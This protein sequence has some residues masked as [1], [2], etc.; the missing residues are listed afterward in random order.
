MVLFL[1]G[2]VTVNNF[3]FNMM[4][5]INNSRCSEKE[6]KRKMSLSKR[7]FSEHW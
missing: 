2:A 5:Y 1:N 3:M 6:A 4:Y 7:S